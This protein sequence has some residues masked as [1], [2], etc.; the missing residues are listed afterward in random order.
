M[1]LPKPLQQDSEVGELVS[2]AGLTIDKDVT[3]HIVA[4]LRSGVRPINLYAM[5]Q[6][7]SKKIGQKVEDLKENNSKQATEA[8]EMSKLSDNDA[9]NSLKSKAR[10][11]KAWAL[12]DKPVFNV[13]SPKKTN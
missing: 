8:K 5:L 3:L 12:K 1:E 2:L 4:L 7:L 13:Y 10:P 9:N 6:C 11:M